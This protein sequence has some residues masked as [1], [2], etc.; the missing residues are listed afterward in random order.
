[1][2]HA[3]HS[4]EHSQYEIQAGQHDTFN[5][6]VAGENYEIHPEAPLNDDGE[7]VDLQHGHTATEPE[8]WSGRPPGRMVRARLASRMLKS[9]RSPRSQS[10]PNF[11][12]RPAEQHQEAEVPQHTAPSVAHEAAEQQEDLAEAKPADAQVS[13]R[14][15]VETVE[16]E[17]DETDQADFEVEQTVAHL[18]PE[19]VPAGNERHAAFPVLEAPSSAPE[20]RTL[21]HETLGR[22]RDGI[23]SR[24][25]RPG[26]AERGWRR[27]T[28]S[29]WSRK[30]SMPT[31][32]TAIAGFQRSPTSTKTR[33]WLPKNAARPV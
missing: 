11:D 4:H 5:A 18:Q 30:R 7:T 27:I 13:S 29:T 6:A 15:E 32:A 33:S 31:T 20:G 1:M 2:S 8:Q 22:R 28:I 17:E 3:D 12:L 16:I 10:S 23:P 19:D 14:L 21:E 24:A 25:R 26:S 9:M